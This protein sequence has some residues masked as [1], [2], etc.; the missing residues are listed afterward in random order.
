MDQSILMLVI[1]LGAMALSVPIALALAFAAMLAIMTASDTPAAMVI[2]SVY[3][4]VDNFTLMGIPFFMLAGN[5]MKSGGVSRRLINFAKILVGGFPGGLGHVAILTCM[6]FAAISGSGPATVAAVGLIMIPYMVEAGYDKNYAS[7]LTAASG[8]IGVIIPPSIP[9]ILYAVMANVS[10]ASIFAAGF[11]PGITIGLLLMLVNY[12]VSRRRGYRGESGHLDLVTFVRAFREAFLSLMMPVIILGG[13]Y[14][15]IFT[16]T[17]AAGVAVVYGFFI[18]TFV[19]R[20]IRWKDLSTILLESA[21]MSAICI[22]ILG[23]AAPFGWVL[24]IE[25]FP[26]RMAALMSDLLQ[27]PT[28]FLL[29]INIFFLF[30]GCLMSA[31]AA[32]IILTPMIL[33]IVQNLD[34]NLVHFGIIMVIN[35]ELGMLTPPFGVNLFVACGISK[36]GIEDIVRPMMGFI[37]ATLVGLFLITYV[38]WLSLAVPWLMG[39]AI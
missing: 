4:S 11:V 23:M 16:P 20:E 34:I 17:E 27:T 13:I 9:M 2:Q 1:F 19:Y 30:W 5:L 36:I 33:P 3:S 8:G 26:T 12:I 6:I 29:A 21:V 38:P 28:M 25:N 24:T 22:V 35:L 14:S 32:L 18:G 15:G 39:L 10:I 7:A 31:T 37:I